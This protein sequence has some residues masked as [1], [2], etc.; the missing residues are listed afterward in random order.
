MTVPEAKRSAEVYETPLSPGTPLGE[1]RL[2]DPVEG[3]GDVHEALLGGH[4]FDIEVAL[5]PFE[6]ARG[7]MQ[8]PSLP[9]NAAMLFVFEREGYLSFWMRNTLIPLDILF[10]NAEGVVVDIQTMDTQLGALDSELQRYL[11]A[12]PAR[13]AIEMNAGLTDAL[14]I[15]PGAQV[16]FR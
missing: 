10:L 1:F 2:P 6:I 7:L 9:A 12:R 15:L 13:Y 14:E 16:L 4:R 8:R 5:T 11:S 3:I